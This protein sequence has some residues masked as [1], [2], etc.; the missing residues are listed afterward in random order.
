MRIGIDI[1]GVLTN[2]QQF[3]V[4]YFT[5]F[6]YDNKIAYSVK[7]N[8]FDYDISK[9]FGLGKKEED[10]F[11]GEYLDYY[12]KKERARE[13]ASEVIKILKKQGHE[14]YI[15]TARWLTNRDD[16]LGKKNEKHCKKMA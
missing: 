6:C 11:W 14:I 12:A 16:K 15:V 7:R 13:F 8:N 4:D 1:D 10:A 5:K 9:S 3:S 2:L